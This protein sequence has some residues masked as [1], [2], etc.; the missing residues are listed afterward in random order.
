MIL[1]PMM[2]EGIIPLPVAFISTISKDGVRNIAPY[3]CVMPVLRPLDLICIASAFKRDTLVNIRETGQFV[4][5]MVGADFSDKV[6][7]TARFSPPE[8]DEFELAKLNEKSSETVRP[9]GIAGGYAWMECEL[10]KLYEETQYVLVMGR[11]LRL[12]VDDA[13]L[14]AQGEFDV[15]KARPLM[16]AGTRKGMDFCTVAGIDHFEPF[17]AMFADGRDPLENK[18]QE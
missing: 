5:N 16:M 17:S 10:F 8:A 9:P 14:N 15:T 1:K 11:V 6:I 3:A 7:P 12:E 13:V 4:I 18:Y 2:R